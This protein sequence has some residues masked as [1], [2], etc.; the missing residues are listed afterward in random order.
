[1]MTFSVPV[2]STVTMVSA[3]MIEGNA[4]KMSMT[5]WSRMSNL[6]PK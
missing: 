3:R 1:M 6:P 5:R 2:P 4:M